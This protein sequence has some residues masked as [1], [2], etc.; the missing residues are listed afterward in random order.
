MSPPFPLKRLALHWLS[1]LVEEYRDAD[2]LRL[3]WWQASIGPD[4]INEHIG[5]G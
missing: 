4:G 2:A 3:L 5:R 1:I